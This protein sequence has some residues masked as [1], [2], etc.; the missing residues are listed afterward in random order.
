MEI[1][2]DKKQ[3]Y[4]INKAT[5]YAITQSLVIGEDDDV[6][7]KIRT[8]REPPSIMFPYNYE[9][10]IFHQG[11]RVYFDDPERPNGYKK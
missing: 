8:R 2:V 9:L 11:E 6:R 5:E 4:N 7:I 3:F 10:R 1:Y